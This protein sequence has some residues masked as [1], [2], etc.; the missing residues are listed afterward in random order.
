MTV[1][2]LANGG[3]SLPI[4]SG[5]NHG[6]SEV[7][8]ERRMTEFL[9]RIAL[10]I[11]TG[12]VLAFF[13]EFFFLNEGPVNELI[14]AVEAGPLAVLESLAILTLFYGFFF[15]VWLLLAI[16]Y[17]R[18]RSVAA[19]LLAGIFFGWATEG[20][21][22]PLIYEEGFLWPAISWHVLV[23]VLFG[24]WFLRIVLHRGN[25]ALTA[26]LAVVAGAAWGYWATWILTSDEIASMSVENFADF[27]FVASL[28]LVGGHALLAR[29]GGQEFK[30]HGTELALYTLSLLFL[31]GVQFM[32]YPL[33]VTIAIAGVL[34]L[35]ACLFRNRTREQRPSILGSFD[36]VVPLWH[37]L[38]LFLA[39]LTATFVF[40]LAVENQMVA[41]VGVIA[42]A[43]NV[44][45]C[46]GIAWAVFRIY[47]MPR[48]A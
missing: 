13:S 8:T 3:F 21:L 30:P 25:P 19:L 41:D 44:V 42:T 12:A 23:D 38:L 11:G 31:I 34:V 20:T 6:G 9:K 5:Y 22:I 24:W 48:L 43:L 32:A 4:V 29:F 14:R 16:S 10:I 26:A 37:Y 18:V 35:C 40:A 17:F 2:D 36:T 1:E 45:A 46:A 15:A 28:L 39:P 7:P 27:A 47:R 33:E